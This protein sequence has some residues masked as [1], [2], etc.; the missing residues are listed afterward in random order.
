MT[1]YRLRAFMLAVPHSSAVV[2]VFDDKRSGYN[3]VC[4]VA[5]R[6]LRQYEPHARFTL[7]SR[8][9]TAGHM[10]AG[11]MTAGPMTAGHMAANLLTAVFSPDIS[12]TL[13][14]YDEYYMTVTYTLLT[15]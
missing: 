15:T 14:I 5:C 6:F 8:Q 11:H 4:H 1:T 7:V 12:I 2:H 3:V 9:L 10:T 13:A